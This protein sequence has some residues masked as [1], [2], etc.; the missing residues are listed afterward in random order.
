MRFFTHYIFTLYSAEKKDTDPGPYLLEP[1]TT[2]FRCAYDA[3]CPGNG[4]VSHWCMGPELQWQEKGGEIR[5]VADYVF[6]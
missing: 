6:C 5:S 4:T 3:F 1:R 2:I